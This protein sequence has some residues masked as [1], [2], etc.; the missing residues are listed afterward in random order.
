MGQV[1]FSGL[2]KGGKYYPCISLI[3][4]N[5]RVDFVNQD[6]VFDKDNSEQLSEFMDMVFKVLNGK[7]TNLEHWPK[8]KYCATTDH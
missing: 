6:I 8:G 5:V 3:E 4:D 2:H 1:E 7:K